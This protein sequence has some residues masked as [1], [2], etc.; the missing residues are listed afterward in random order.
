MYSFFFN[1]VLKVEKIY[2]F[3]IQNYTKMLLFYTI[4]LYFDRFYVFILFII[5]HFAY[6]NWLNSTKSH[7]WVYQELKYWIIESI[8]YIESF[9]SV[10]MAYYLLNPFYFFWKTGTFSN[11]DIILFLI[12]DKII[13]KILRIIMNNKLAFI[14]VN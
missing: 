3:F 11:R 5:D 4:L 12:C 9:L 2:K 8:Y 10:I 6:F 14:K 13:N 7:S 1:N